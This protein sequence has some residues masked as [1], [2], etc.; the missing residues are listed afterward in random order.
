MNLNKTPLG[1]IVPSMYP[2][3][4]NPVTLAWNSYLASQ[5]KDK[6][7][8]DF[9]P[10]YVDPPINPILAAFSRRGVAVNPMA[11]SNP[12]LMGN[13]FNAP[14]SVKGA[15]RNALVTSMNRSRMAGPL[16]MGSLDTSSLEAFQQS[17]MNGKSFGVSNLALVGIGVG[18]L[19][20]LPMLTG[21]GGRRR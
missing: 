19:V 11:M 17:L 20:L 13:K 15:T 9:V 16:G 10:G 8:G 21:G 5:K 14:K 2:I 1:D 3:P 6:G 7:M 18:A 12:V 4:Q